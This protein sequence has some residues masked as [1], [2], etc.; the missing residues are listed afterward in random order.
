MIMSLAD[1]HDIKN[2][3][4]Y[5]GY[6]LFYM[7][8]S[9][10]IERHNLQ[11]EAIFSRTLEVRGQWT[12]F[13][14]ENKCKYHSQRY[15]DISPR[16]SSCPPRPFSITCTLPP[17]IYTP[18]SDNRQLRCWNIILYCML[19]WK[20]YIGIQPIVFSHCVAIVGS[21]VPNLSRSI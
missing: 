16:I 5:K 8:L 4:S 2:I 12:C 21:S 1:C 9:F 7:S 3:R 11:P 17:L 19:E 6:W 18:Q 14:G 13:R 20:N 15:R 10:N